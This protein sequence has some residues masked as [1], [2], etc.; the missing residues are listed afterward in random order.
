[1][2]GYWLGP[3]SAENI[4]PHYFYHENINGYEAFC[5]R[6]AELDT[7]NTENVQILL[8]FTGRTAK[9][10]D[11]EEDSVYT[12]GWDPDCNQF[13][14]VVDFL[15]VK[16]EPKGWLL[17]IG[18]GDPMEWKNPQNPFRT[19][20]RIK[21][22][23]IPTFMAWNTMKRISGSQCFQVENILVMLED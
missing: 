13:E 4:V 8:L 9:Q 10:S 5:K 18:V 23:S 16:R 6:I 2:A 20:H 14:N 19:D 15:T 17:K 1:M 12:I 11:E 7:L 21:L 3:T 22:T